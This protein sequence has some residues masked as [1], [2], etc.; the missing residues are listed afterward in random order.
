MAIIFDDM[1]AE[2]HGR[3]MRLRLQRM[4]AQVFQERQIVLVA[5]VVETTHGPER[6]APIEAE[7][8]KGIGFREVDERA[9]RK[10]CP[11]PEIA[12][13]IITFAAFGYENVHVVLDETLNLPQAK[14]DFMR[15]V[16]VG[17]HRD[18]TRVKAR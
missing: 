16:D 12:D 10:T 5:G 4:E 11:Q 13:G 18:V 1:F 3:Q 17:P 9:R 8:T 2:R 7:R 14:T 15:R 6:L